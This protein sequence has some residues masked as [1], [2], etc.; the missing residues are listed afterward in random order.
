LYE[1]E[2]RGFFTTFT[3]SYRAERRMPHAFKNE[4]ERG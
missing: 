1:P 2:P 3:D 4:R